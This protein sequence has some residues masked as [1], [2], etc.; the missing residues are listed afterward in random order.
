MFWRGEIGRA[1]LHD[2][3]AH[4]L[5]AKIEAVDSRE[6]VAEAAAVAQDLG[7]AKTYDAEYVV[8]ARRLKI[9]LLTV[10][11]RLRSSVKALIDAVSPAEVDTWT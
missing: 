8:L 6:L 7:W 3:V 11:A 10:D 1:A 2:A 9:P 5:A 4:L